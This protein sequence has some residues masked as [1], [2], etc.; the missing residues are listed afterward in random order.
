TTIYDCLPKGIPIPEQV[1]HD[2]DEALAYARGRG[3]HPHDVHG[4]NVLVHEGRGL[5]ADVSDF[6]E[7]GESTQWEDLK[8]AYYRIY[9]PFITRFGLR[10]PYFILEGVRFLHRHVRGR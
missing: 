3:L 7:P 1:I 10:V 5:I 4:R 8:A 9:R 2:V 6:L